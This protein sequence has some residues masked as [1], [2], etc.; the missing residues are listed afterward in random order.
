MNDLLQES[1]L[2]PSPTPTLAADSSV[3]P[4]ERAFSSELLAALLRFRAGDFTAHLPSDL[5]GIDGKIA[6]AFNDVLS[7]SA[8]R[9]SETARVCRVVGKEGKLKQRMTVP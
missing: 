2:Q 7:V 9:A 8:R 4:V 6:D 3:S 1:P 5:P